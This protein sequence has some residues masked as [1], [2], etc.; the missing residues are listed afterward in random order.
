MPGQRV[1]GAERLVEQEQA[2]RLTRAR[3]SATRWRWPPDST[4]G[5]S[6]AAVA[7]G[8][9][10]PRAAAARSAPVGAALADADIVEHALPG[11]QARVL[12]QHA[13]AVGQAGEGAAVEQDVARRRRSRARRGGAAAC[14]CRSRSGRRSR[15]TRRARCARSRSLSTGRS[16]KRLLD[17]R[18]GGR[19]RPCAGASA[20]SAAAISGR[21]ATSPQGGAHASG[22]PVLV[23]RV[24]GEAAALEPA[25]RARRRA[26]RAGRRRGCRAPRRRS[27]GT[28]GRSWSCSRC[29]SEAE[30]VSATIRVSH[31]M[32][33]A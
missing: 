31:M 24:P 3:A 19:R 4:A 30:I 1:E 33:S 8:R 6:S 32:P 29:P 14:S 18:R 20:P 28:R 9:H 26:C 2:R 22:L 13:H 15:R 23:G 11:Q 27:A 12:E 16:P 5:Q 21:S 25:R 7:P 10:R 17:A